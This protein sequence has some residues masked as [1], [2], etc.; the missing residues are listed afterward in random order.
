[1]VGK[2]LHFKDK[3]ETAYSCNLYIGGS[4]I[5]VCNFTN[6]QADLVDQVVDHIT[7]GKFVWNKVVRSTLEGNC[8]SEKKH[9]HEFETGKHVNTS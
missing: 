5:L 2:Y 6:S 1:M 3:K 7:Y 8:H 9:N 4:F